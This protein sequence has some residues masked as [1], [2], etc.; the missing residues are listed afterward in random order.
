MLMLGYPS[1]EIADTLGK[2]QS[3]VRT[4]GSKLPKPP[5]FR[6]KLFSQIPEHKEE[7]Y[8]LTKADFERWCSNNN[9]NAS[10][11]IHRKTMWKLNKYNWHW[12][13]IPLG[14]KVIAKK[15]SITLK[16]DS[17]DYRK[18]KKYFV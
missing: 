17:A 16:K 10:D 4:I 1:K 8:F 6:F 7:Y 12:Y 9:L 5:R 14:S 2:S 3:W 13:E 18:F 11:I 15:G